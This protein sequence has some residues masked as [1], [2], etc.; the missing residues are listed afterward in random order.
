M[1]KQ[2]YAVREL[3]ILT[4]DEGAKMTELPIVRSRE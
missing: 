1:K 4:S 2:I 3:N